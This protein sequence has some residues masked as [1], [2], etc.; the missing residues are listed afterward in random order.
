MDCVDNVDEGLVKEPLNKSHVGCG[1]IGRDRVGQSSVFRRK[2]R[3]RTGM[4]APKGYVISRSR[5]PPLPDP[6]FAG[7]LGRRFWA[8]PRRAE[9]CLPKEDATRSGMRAPKGYIISRSRRPPLPDPRV[10]GPLG[11]RFWAPLRYAPW[12]RRPSTTFVVRLVIIPILPATR[13]ARICSE[14]P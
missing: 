7:P 4:R 12:H 14:V 13:S 11:R 2:M 6:R 5:R 9:Q 10:A 3:P 1:K 8:R